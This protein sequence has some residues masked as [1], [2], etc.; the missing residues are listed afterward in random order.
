M[1]F[2]PPL[3][4]FS[5]TMWSVTVCFHA[6][7]ATCYIGLLSGL[8]LVSFQL[9]KF[10]SCRLNSHCHLSPTTLSSP[11]VKYRRAAQ[12]FHTLWNI[13]EYWF[14]FSESLSLHICCCTNRQLSGVSEAVCVDCCPRFTGLARCLLD[15]FDF[16]DNKRNILEIWK[17]L[18]VF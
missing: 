14:W 3:I 6:D 7:V 1:L 2:L 17:K 11:L 18:S 5:I 9:F 10:S 4:L 15:S 12:Y 16:C 13:P 8:V